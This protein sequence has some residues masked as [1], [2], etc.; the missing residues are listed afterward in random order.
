M[1]DVLNFY[2]IFVN[3][4]I[5]DPVLFIILVYVWAAIILVHAKANTQVFL[6][7]M[8][9]ITGLLSIEFP[10]LRWGLALFGMGFVGWTMMRIR[11][12]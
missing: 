4:L 3:Q 9:V 8:T 7:V 10:V 12:E 2:D 5:G 11:R 6:F 1:V